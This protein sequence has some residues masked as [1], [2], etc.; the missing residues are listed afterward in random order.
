MQNNKDQRT[1]E[2]KR[3]TVS[4][5]MYNNKLLY[6]GRSIFAINLNRSKLVFLKLNESE[7]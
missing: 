3:K 2:K 1:L 5:S 4:K 6:K 7:L